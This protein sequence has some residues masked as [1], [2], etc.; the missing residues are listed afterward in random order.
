MIHL[1]EVDTGENIRIKRNKRND[2]MTRRLTRDIYLYNFFLQYYPHKLS[3][4][5]HYIK[6][7]R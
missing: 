6:H 7:K 4:H 3:V 2:K 5:F 1:R